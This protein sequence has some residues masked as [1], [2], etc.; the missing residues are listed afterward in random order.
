MPPIRI[1]PSVLCK[2]LRCVLPRLNAVKR[3]VDRVQFD[4][5][6]GKFV[7][8]KTVQ[9]VQ[10]RGLKTNLQVEAQLMVK[11]PEEYVEDWADAGASTIIFHIESCR[12]KA[13]IL[14]LILHI[15]NHKCSVGIALN[16]ETPARAAFPFLKRVDHVLVMTVHPGRM[17][18]RLIP[19]TLEKVKAI[20]A[21]APQLDVEVDGGINE[22]TIQA[23]VKAG[24]NL[25]VVGSAIY[26]KDAHA[27]V[28]R[29]WKLA[30]AA[31]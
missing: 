5:M 16:P 7:K 31:K 30:R 4:V 20:R 28:A 29:L 26:N 18:Q 27:A 9:A 24:A 10:L 3:C 23:A 11:N 6:D 19:K 15:R 13:E 1:V 22:R 14:G 2:N 21:R 25:L 17:G 8:N 12:N